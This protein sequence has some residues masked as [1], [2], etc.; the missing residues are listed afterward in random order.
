MEEMGDTCEGI[1]TDM[2]GV[3]RGIGPVK[4]EFNGLCD[5][6]SEGCTTGQLAGC[7]DKNE[8]DCGDELC[9]SFCTVER[10]AECDEIEEDPDL[11]N[12]DPCCSWNGGGNLCDPVGASASCMPDEPISVDGAIAGIGGRLTE[13]EG[14]VNNLPDDAEDIISQNG[15]DD[16]T[17]EKFK[18]MRDK[19]KWIYEKLDKVLKVYNS[20]GSVCKKAYDVVQGGIGCTPEQIAEAECGDK[21][22]QD[23]GDEQCCSFCTVERLA[24]C[25]EIG[26]D[27][28]CDDNLCCE[29]DNECKPVAAEKSC[30]S[31]KQTGIAASLD[32]LKESCEILD[33]S[34]NTEIIGPL[35][36]L[37]NKIEKRFQVLF[38]GCSAGEIAG[39]E[40]GDKDEQEC[41]DVRCC[42]FC[43]LE[44]L[45]KCDEIGDDT[46][47]DDN[48]CC[49]W[50]NECKPVAGSASCMS[51]KVTDP[52]FKGLEGL[53][54]REYFNEKLTRV[55]ERISKA[56]TGC[57]DEEIAA[58]N[59]DG[60]NEEECGDELCCFFCTEDELNEC[61]DEEDP[62]SCDDDLCCF[63]NG[64]DCDYVA[65][66]AVCMPDDS[67]GLGGSTGGFFCN[68]LGDSIWGEILEAFDI[69]MEFWNKAQR[70]RKCYN[71]L[72]DQIDKLDTRQ[73]T[74]ASQSSQTCNPSYEEAKAAYTK[75]LDAVNRRDSNEYLFAIYKDPQ[76]KANAEEADREADSYRSGAATY[77]EFSPSDVSVYEG[78]EGDRVSAQA[79]TW[80]NTVLGGVSEEAGT[81]KFTLYSALV[82][83]L[84][85]V[86]GQ[87]ASLIR[88]LLSFINS[89]VNVSILG[90]ISS[91]VN[92]LS[93]IA[94]IFGV[95][96]GLFNVLTGT[97]HEIAN[98][99]DTVDALTV[100]NKEVD[101][102]GKWMGT[103]YMALPV[104]GEAGI[105]M[106]PMWQEFGSTYYGVFAS[107]KG[108]TDRSPESYGDVT[109][110]N[111]MRPMY[112]S[113][114]DYIR[115]IE[116]WNKNIEYDVTQ[117]I[118]EMPITATI[119]PVG[120]ELN[121]G[122]FDDR[123]LADKPGICEVKGLFR[124][125]KSKINEEWVP[126]GMP[127][128][129]H[130]VMWT[131]IFGIS[132][133][134]E[135]RDPDCNILI[136]NFGSD[137][138]TYVGLIE[139]LED[140]NYHVR[141]HEGTGEDITLEMLSEYCQVWFIDSKD[142]SGV[143]PEEGICEELGLEVVKAARNGAEFCDDA[144]VSSGTYTFVCE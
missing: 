15:G 9:C 118:K 34:I 44:D 82:Q 111:Y 112:A 102:L 119:L 4:G 45:A 78:C 97:C 98:S 138:D 79:Y 92:I 50:D 126:L 109:V 1:K 21:N 25:D 2:E 117:I 65:S 19:L 114:P 41:G 55:C 135:M 144:H 85:D 66:S 89:I 36:R 13:L 29:W 134:I 51:A 125:I 8:Q 6:I 68:L 10:L 70:Y 76:F 137:A 140:D 54:L 33:E 35:K 110:S 93:I 42:S 96:L 120:I 84:A 86:I 129:D 31:V 17:Y 116:E 52:L 80:G 63:W 27:P 73:S 39:A 75:F 37:G 104:M 105:I 38:F 121:Y 77:L 143:P 16:A 131:E 127:Y 26:D 87:F 58:A 108:M 14:W 91:I 71:C 69:F 103:P 142:D 88:A 5:V 136:Y 106:D 132:P 81:A 62:D 43:T 122:S 40:C 53:N 11:C 90:W 83:G 100:P 115:F 60:K 74:F 67:P 59:C 47:C 123:E 30:V 128:E 23:C 28:A 12:D 46:A 101:K 141:Y 99:Q 56:I 107:P 139:T 113:K 49:E 20:I 133:D 64:N 22:E 57:T 61:S 130:E 32:K 48:P 94:D 124:T 3:T 18:D 7:G 95:V 72:D 24:E